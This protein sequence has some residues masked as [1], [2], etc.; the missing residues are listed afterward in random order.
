MSMTSSAVRRESSS[1]KA[2]ASSRS[3]PSTPAR[4][5]FFARDLLQNDVQAV[6]LGPGVLDHRFRDRRDE[7][8]LLLDGST[9]PQLNCDDRHVRLPR[10]FRHTVILAPTAIVP[11]RRMS[12][13]DATAMDEVVG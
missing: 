13:V 8:P 9:L 10:F 12:R 11:S 6:P 2:H 5:Q 3:T 4:P 7:R 1:S